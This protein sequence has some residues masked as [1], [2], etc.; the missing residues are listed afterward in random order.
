MKYYICG[1][2]NSRIIISKQLKRIVNNEILFDNKLFTN[3]IFSDSPFDLSIKLNKDEIIKMYIVYCN[4]R[5]ILYNYLLDA[6]NKNKKT[7][8]KINILTSF[9]L[10]YNNLNFSFD[11][12]IIYYCL[13]REYPYKILILRILIEYLPDE[14]IMIILK[15]LEKEV[16]VSFKINKSSLENSYYFCLPS[17]LY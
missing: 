5:E 17:I 8:V 12:N 2:S 7:Q 16:I 11:I 3:K 6:K 9:E 10:S 4:N 13:N 1:Y 15:Y 14:L